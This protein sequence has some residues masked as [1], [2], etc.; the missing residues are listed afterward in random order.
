MARAMSHAVCGNMWALTG[1]IPVPSCWEGM[2]LLRFRKLSVGCQPLGW[3]QM[4]V[5]KE[6][7]GTSGI[8]GWTWPPLAE[9]FRHPSSFLTELLSFLVAAVIRRGRGSPLT[10]H[11]R[12]DG[13]RLTVLSFVPMAWLC[14][15]KV[16]TQ[17]ACASVAARGIASQD[18]RGA[19]RGRDGGGVLRRWMDRQKRR[20][21]ALPPILGRR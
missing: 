6:Q 17:E 5:T 19:L 11:G 18:S 3:S 20:H 12:R 7:R 8:L 1:R 10:D 4:P 15:D 16:R 9:L 14:K 21:A 2:Q 13:R